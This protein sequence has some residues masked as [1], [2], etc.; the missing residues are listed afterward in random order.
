M[1]VFC[2]EGNSGGNMYYL[3]NNKITR[4]ITFSC[5]IVLLIGITK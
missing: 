1:S 4:I 2:V 5:I 3:T